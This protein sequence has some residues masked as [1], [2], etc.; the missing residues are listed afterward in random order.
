M[1]RCIFRTPYLLATLM[2]L[3]C[4]ASLSYAT[5][6]RGTIVTTSGERFEN[7]KF[8]VDEIYKVL[9]FEQD[10]EKRNISFEKVQ[11]VFDPD[12]WDITAEVFGTAEIFG[13]PFGTGSHRTGR[14]WKVA[15][16]P[17]IGYNFPAG[18]LYD[19]IRGSFDFGGAIC[20]AVTHEF[21]LRLGAGKLGMQFDSQYDFF[22]RYASW[23]AMHY[24][25][26][27]QFNSYISSSKEKY[28][29][30]YIYGGIGSVS[31]RLKLIP[32]RPNPYGGNY[33]SGNEYSDSR[34]SLT[35]GV[36][37]TTMISRTIGIDLGLH[38][39][40]V[41]VGDD[42]SGYFSSRPANIAHIFD[43]HVGLIFYL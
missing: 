37:M 7:V 31:Y 11:S 6:F 20:I 25:A 34:F 15:F 39:D 12:G 1:T 41:L 32:I 22:G 19:G 36:G 38:T 10:K 30:Y 13:S 17:M 23:S 29:M 33:I 24:Y 43:P 9:K 18:D 5:S 40:L 16:S 26:A 42:D 14:R 4:S 28:S 21:G 27:V 2:L 3:I 8:E 35:W